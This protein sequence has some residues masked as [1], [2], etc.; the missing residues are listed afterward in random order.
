MHRMF[1]LAAALT[2]L[3]TWTA[4]AAPVARLS[5]IGFEPDAPKTAILPRQADGSFRSGTWKLLLLDGKRQREAGHGEI[6]S[7]ARWNAIG[8]SAQTLALPE[9]LAPGT[10][11]LVQ[12][13]TRIA[14]D[15]R[16]A[17]GRDANLVRAGMKALY[18]NRASI[19]T[20][21][22]FAGRWAR[23]AGHPD[24]LVHRHPATGQTGTFSA[25][26]GWYDA[27]DYGKY[28]VNSGLT[29]WLLLDLYEKAPAVFD[30]LR[31]GIP[32]GPEPE[33][34]REVRWNL[35]WMLAMQ[36][37]DGGVY[38]KLTARNFDALDEMPHRDLSERVASPKSTAATLDFALV[39]AK[40]SRLWVR[41]DTAFAGQCRRAAERAWAW[42]VAHPDSIFVQPSD[43]KTGEYGD[44]HLSDERFAAATELALATGDR[45]LFLPFR[46]QIARFG[47]I[48][49][50]QD[51]GA[52]G[53]YTIVAHPGF[54]AA[55][56]AAA[57]TTLGE[58]AALLWHRVPT[59][60]YATTMDSADFVWGSNGVAALH[61][62]HLFHAWLATGN[63]DFRRGAAANLDYLLGKNPL[64]MCFVTGLGTRTSLHP[65]HRPSVGDTVALP[66]PGFLVGGP[67]PGGQD[68][69][70]APW[71]LSDYRVPGKPA[72]DWV[73]HEKSY[74]T[75]EVAINWN[76]SLVHLAGLLAA[77][78]NPPQ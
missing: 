4:D 73:D 42:S 9:H 24:T 76:A 74:A 41:F 60:G 1:L 47:Q 77:V 12:G 18:H 7:P 33:L 8:D 63:P 44:R 37:A 27:G 25:P 65:H 68:V 49:S 2:A 22:A 62:I 69:G 72:L 66:V 59:N 56:T 10:Y 52:L 50:W 34:L 29:G 30:T 3:P 45:D 15:F 28:I 58:G 23:P 78:R 54:F 32:A 61:G 13:K 11:R 19:A 46:G 31:W 70:S 55:E 64:D 67:Q 21:P 53:L 35:D 75:N 6:P 57:R 17:A 48:P 71:Q 43:V 51:M 36:D 38:H 16:V 5:Q 40:A 14:P 26:K 20:D 39:A